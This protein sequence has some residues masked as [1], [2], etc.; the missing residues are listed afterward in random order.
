MRRASFLKI[1]P[2]AR[3][4]RV[5][6]KQICHQKKQSL[7]GT[8]I[9][10]FSTKLSDDFFYPHAIYTVG[11]GDECQL[12]TGSIQSTPTPQR[13]ELKGNRYIAAS[14]GWMHNFVVTDNHIVYG[15]GQNTWGQI[16]I[17]FRRS[18][19]ILEPGEIHTLEI[20]KVKQIQTG[21]AH[22]LCLSKDNEVFTW[23]NSEFGQLGVG[24]TENKAFETPNRVETFR[25]LVR[26]TSLQFR[27]V[28]FSLS[29]C[30]CVHC[31][32]TDQRVE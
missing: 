24:K 7:L 15:W 9:R 28:P 27:S 21:R 18:T 1:L 10:P 16:G 14:S 29:V 26:T 8:F 31:D 6:A 13:V 17:L 12:G 20:L 22:S 32:D 3:Y 4:H 2:T 30:V 25:S 23:G 19:K 11:K 5:L